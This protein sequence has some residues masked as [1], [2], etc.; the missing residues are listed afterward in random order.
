MA[1]VKLDCGIL[2]STLWLERE[3]REVFI[4]ALLM[5]EP[6]ELKE[7]AAQIEVDSLKE[8]G[9]VVPAGWYGFVPAA[10]VGIIARAG[11]EKSVGIEALRKLGSPESDSR[12]PDFDGRRL[13]R[14]DGGY[15]ILNFMRYRERDYTTAERSRRYRQRKAESSRRDVNKSRRDDTVP[16][17]DITEAEAEAEAEAGTVPPKPPVDPEAPERSAP[18]RGRAGGITEGKDSSNVPTT[19]QS[20]RIARI[21]HRKETTPWDAKEIAAYRK[22]G[23][24]PV[25]DLE[26][27]EK[28]Y[29]AH[30]PP[31]RDVNILRHNLLTFLNNFQGEVDRAKTATTNKHANDRRT[32]S[33]PTQ[34]RATGAANF[35]GR[36]DA[37]IPIWQEPPIDG[38]GAE[39]PQPAPEIPGLSPG[40]GPSAG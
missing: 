4:T 14:I 40:A 35:A 22:L 20:K 29:S 16:L 13:V 15:L 10:G 11:L 25:E 7:E 5:A 31:N 17:R 36:Y 34:H 37:P 33:A 24:I 32:T 26:A 8:T 19:E 23:T 38:E 28:Y 6:L 39:N 12:T 9:W 21:F 3:C 2:N 1:F 30:W 18:P 27:V